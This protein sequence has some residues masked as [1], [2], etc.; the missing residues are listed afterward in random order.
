MVR[1]RLERLLTTSRFGSERF[2][3]EFRAS[4]PAIPWNLMAGMRDKL[5]HEYDDVDLN[6]VW[7]T[8]ARDLPPLVAALQRHS[9]TP[10]NT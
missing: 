2:G 3:S 8:I 6:E 5:M 1:L 4:E 7:E 10:E 9:P